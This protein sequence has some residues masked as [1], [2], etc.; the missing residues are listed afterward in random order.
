[1]SNLNDESSRRLVTEAFGGH[2]EVEE[3][4]RKAGILTI[5]FFVLLP[6]AFLVCL[7]VNWE[8][9]RTCYLIVTAL[10][11]VIMWLTRAY[12]HSARN[13]VTAIHVALMAVIVIAMLVG[14]KTDETM[15]SI[16]HSQPAAYHAAVSEAPVL[17]P[18][19]TDI[20]PNGNET[21]ATIRLREFMTAWQGNSVPNMLPFCLPSW[22]D[23]QKSPEMELWNLILDRIPDS[24]E[25]VSVQGT[26]LD[27]TSTITLHVNFRKAGATEAVLTRMQ[28]LMFRL[29]EEW[30]VD[31]QSLSGTE[32]SADFEI[33]KSNTF[34][35]LVLGT[36]KAP[37]TATP[38]PQENGMI[39]YYNLSHGKYYHTTPT[40]SA[41]SEEYWPLEGKFYYSE[42]NSQTYKAL[43]PCTKCG[44]P[45]R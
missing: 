6:V 5:L 45:A 3:E 16:T 24:Y 38:V 19:T 37:T 15:N 11:L 1:M 41:V 33:A 36:T 26:N 22:V 34:G 44:A 35:G 32:I 21:K 39:L 2:R 17:A 30:Y 40:C 10:C 7:F 31:P 28:I 42:L 9:L 25:V 29:N 4:P 43:I 8:A 20:P 14:Q 23:G 18:A 12:L 13:T 27:N